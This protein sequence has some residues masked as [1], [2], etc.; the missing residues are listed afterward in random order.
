M[1]CSTALKVHSV[2]KL[3]ATCLS[4]TQSTVWPGVEHPDAMPLHL[5]P[6]KS[7]ILRCTTRLPK[8]RAGAYLHLQAK[9]VLHEALRARRVLGAGGA[10]GHRPAVCALGAQADLHG[11]LWVCS[12]V[13]SAAQQSSV[14][15]VE[16][17]PQDLCSM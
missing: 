12:A 11:Q 6:A 7:Y 1:Q 16:Q 13:R 17:L 14:D 15:G 4:A 5:T 9:Q 3:L 10:V 8:R 2:L